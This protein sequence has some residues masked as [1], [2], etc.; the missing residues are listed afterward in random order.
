MNRY[1]TKLIATV[2]LL[3]GSFL[4]IEHLWTAGYLEYELIGHE[5]YGLFC[6]IIAAILGIILWRTKNE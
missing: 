4:Q 6:N 2:L 5:T 1:Y 3:I